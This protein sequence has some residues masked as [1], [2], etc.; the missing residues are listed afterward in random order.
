VN[1]L[2]GEISKKASTVRS[3]RE[4]TGATDINSLV[5]GITTF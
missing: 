3:E 1:L 2:G 4:L 5:E